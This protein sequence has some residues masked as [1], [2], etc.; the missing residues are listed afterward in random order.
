MLELV[1]WK[2]REK[3]RTSSRIK[4]KSSANNAKEIDISMIQPQ[5]FDSANNLNELEDRSFSGTG[6]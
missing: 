5:D 3:M 4:D 2:A 1:A 6:R